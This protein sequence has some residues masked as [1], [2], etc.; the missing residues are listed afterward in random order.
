MGVAATPSFE[1]PTGPQVDEYFGNV[2][3]Y[4]TA[5]ANLFG[6]DFNLQHC[7]K[8]LIG[9]VAGER[10]VERLVNTDGRRF[11]ACTVRS[12]PE[13]QCIIVHNDHGHIDLPMYTEVV[14]DLDT[15]ITLSFFALLQ[16]PQSGGRLVVHGVTDSDDVPRLP[17]GFPD[18]DAIK[19]RYK[20]EAFELDSRDAIIFAA[21]KFY[22][23]VEAVGGA[24]PRITL[25]G[26]LALSND[27]KKIHY[28]N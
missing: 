28:W 3:R 7:I 4:E 23:H 26:F 16:A 18:S 21:G 22:H 19:R 13:R 1:N 25:G 20:N 24:L 27:R 12:L 6:R 5:T 17:G 9:T 14:P 10:P 8:E 11:A 2:D 15:S